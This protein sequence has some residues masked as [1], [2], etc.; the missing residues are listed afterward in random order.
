MMAKQIGSLLVIFFCTAFAWMVLGS[1]THLRTEQQDSELKKQVGQL[2][3]KVQ[4]QLAPM[5]FFRFP[6]RELVEETTGSGEKQ[7]V[8]KNTPRQPELLNGSDINIKL[9]LD[10]RKKGLLWYSTYR[11]DFDAVYSVH[12]NSDSARN[13]YFGYTFPEPD[14]VYDNFHLTVDGEPVADL[15]PV[16]G[17]IVESVFC[18]PGDTKKIGVAYRTQG[19][20]EWWYVF[21]DNISQIKNFNLT[22]ETDFD[23]VDFPENS[24]SPTA[25]EKT[26]AGWLLTWQYENLIS[27]IQIGV[28]MPQRLNPGPFVGRVTIFAPV[29]LFLFF[30]LMFMITMIK[31]VRLHPMNYFFLA[32]AF[33]SFHIL[34][35]YLVDHTNVHLAMAIC[36]VVSIFLVISYMRLVVGDRFAFIE[37]GLSQFV[38]LVL[39]SYAFFLEGYT[40]LSIT[41]VCI[42]TLFI[43]MQFTAKI[44]WTRSFGKQAVSQAGGSSPSSP[45]RT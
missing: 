12:N 5:T 18:E 36:S 42:L 21:G 20:D 15:N 19:M 28:D 3:G 40:G 9:D 25:K 16:N 41:V 33:F 27:G 29:S 7:R 32:A 24:I 17:V 38:Y 35:A 11:V 1:V 2:W 44:D 39:F 13:I 30:F 6:I 14:G 23:G 43:V 45:S 22:V 34:L 10:H 8:W 37:T 31:N 4:K 26:A